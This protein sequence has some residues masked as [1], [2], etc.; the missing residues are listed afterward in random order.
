[1]LEVAC[2]R[3]GNKQHHLLFDII[4]GTLQPLLVIRFLETHWLDY[5]ISYQVV[6]SWS[7]F[8]PISRLADSYSFILGRKN[9]VIRAKR[10]HSV[11]RMSFR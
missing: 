9:I 10:F 5:L 4:D 1:M 11:K 6:K 2:N 8:T 7:S 3:P